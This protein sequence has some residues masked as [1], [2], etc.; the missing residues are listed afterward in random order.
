MLSIAP[1]S[2]SEVAVSYYEKDDYYASGGQDPDAQGQWAG[3][4]AERLGLSGNVDRDV[5]KD[6]LDGQM[7]D[8][9]QL[10]VVREAGGSREHRPRKANR[11]QD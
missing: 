4:G 6:L 11:R 1:I 3:D 10:G 9:T 5:F 7:P 2:S 8:G